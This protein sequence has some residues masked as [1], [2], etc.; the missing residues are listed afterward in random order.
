M[1]MRRARDLPILKS[2]SARVSTSFTRRHTRI[3][4]GQSA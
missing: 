3:S 1:N 2:R 4:D